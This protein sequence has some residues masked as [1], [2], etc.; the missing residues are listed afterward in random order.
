[1]RLLS[2]ALVLSSSL[3]L[4]AEGEAPPAAPAGPAPKL[5][6]LPFAALGGDVP[7]RA[8]SK[9]AGML[10]TEFKSLEAVQL[11]DTRKA[12]AADPFTDGLST[13]RKSVEEAKELRKKRKFRL[14][15]EALNKAL[16]AYKQLSGGI[17]EIG[18]I[19]DAY[20]LS[21]AV[22][23]NTGRDD[24]GLKALTTALALA[25]DRDLPLAQTSPLFSRVVTDARKSVKDTA[26]NVL[27]VES[28][29]AGGAVFV[30]SIPLGGSPLQVTLVP[31]GLHFWKVALANGETVGGVVEVTNGKPTK[32]SGVSTTKDPESR[33]LAQLAQNKLDAEL[34]AAAKEQA[35][36]LSA[37]LLLFG[38]LSKDGKGLALDCFLYVAQSNEI[39]RLQRSA[40]DTELLSAGMEFYNLAGALTAKGAKVGELVK[41]PSAVTNGP[42]PVGTRIAEA[43]Y[44]I[45]PGKELA[46]DG[47]E[48]VEPAKEDGTRKPLEQKSRAP[49]KKK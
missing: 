7:Q 33:L 41:V 17:T 20:A 14:A 22:L 2:A 11:L 35:T 6:V 23:Y 15:D 1:M 24:E 32:V 49:L 30:D 25:P 13:A 3:L 12:A 37:D 31:A 5:A 46:L 45:Q 34:V 48:P 18:E 21:S 44:G 27:L 36:A 42:A 4:A 38:A 9:A 28:T 39:R 40:F 43:K 10:T 29:P 8:G 26:K 47:V 19:A 16:T